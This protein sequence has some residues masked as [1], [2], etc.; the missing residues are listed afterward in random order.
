[1]GKALDI[2][3]GRKSS[4]FSLLEHA[5]TRNSYLKNRQQAV[6]SFSQSDVIQ[7]LNL[8]HQEQAL[9]RV[10]H[11]MKSKNMLDAFDM[12]ESYCH[13]LKQN[14]SLIEKKQRMP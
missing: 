10:E 6:F 12:I 2:L 8:G 3:L 14:M 7:L 1:M 9:L 4:K 11:V 5:I 13:L